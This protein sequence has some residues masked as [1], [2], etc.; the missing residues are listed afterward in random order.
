LV[1]LVEGTLEKEEQRKVEKHLEECARCQESFQRLQTSHEMLVAYTPP[2]FQTTL[3]IWPKLQE[4]IAETPSN[5]QFFSKWFRRVRLSPAY[6]FAVI[7]CLTLA[8]LCTG[9]VG[10]IAFQGDTI[11]TPT[12]TASYALD[13]VMSTSTREDF[14]T[15]GYILPDAGTL[16]GG[17]E[18]FLLEEAIIISEQPAHL[19]F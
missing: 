9:V 4:K 16:F 1:G 11:D 14:R 18:T 12:P 7:A 17:T 5:W 13:N 6:Q 2:E 3:D 10:Y 8:I 19:T 15:E